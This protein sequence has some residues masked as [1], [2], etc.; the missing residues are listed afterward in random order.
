M[1]NETKPLL[2]ISHKTSDKLIADEIAKFVEGRTGGNVRVFQSSSFATESPKVGRSLNRELREK[3]AEASVV[4]LI[5]TYPDQDWN[6]CMWEC[7]IASDPATPEAKIIVWQC[8]KHVPMIF[9]DQVFV[10]ARALLDVQKFTSELLTAPDFFPGFATAITTFAAQGPQVL[11]AAADLLE[12][13]KPVL[14]PSEDEAPDWA[15]FPLL[16][17]E[18]DRESTT[19][20]ADAQAD[21]R[22]ALFAESFSAKCQVVA[23]DKAGEQI[24]G[25]AGC[26]GKS[27]KEITDAWRV[28]HPDSSTAWLESVHRQLSDAAGSRIPTVDWQLVPDKIGAI[29][30]APV[31]A[32]VRPRDNR[33]CTRFDLYFLPFVPAP[34]AKAIEINVPAGGGTPTP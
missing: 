9:A 31:L 19:A 24:F 2:F 20:I 6:Y 14:P 1:P 22:A 25:L 29:W 5:Y 18:L 11:D 32:C 7:G 21:A 4:V 17:L 12:K 8:G 27:L 10:N 15:P 34:G 30:Y 16:Q 13:L 33:G 3:A 26:K 28:E 23:D